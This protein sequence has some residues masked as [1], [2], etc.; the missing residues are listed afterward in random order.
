MLFSKLKDSGRPAVITLVLCLMWA[1]ACSFI[2]DYP[3]AF[4][5][6]FKGKL[7]GY[8]PPWVY[9]VPLILAALFFVIFFDEYAKGTLKKQAII[10]ARIV[11]GY[12][13][14][15]FLP[16]YIIGMNLT[17]LVLWV[18]LPIQLFGGFIII[19]LIS[20]AIRKLSESPARPETVAPIAS[21][22]AEAPR[23]ASTDKAAL[24]N[25]WNLQEN[26]SQEKL[27]ASYLRLAENSPQSIL[28]K[29]ETEYELLT[30]WR[31]GNPID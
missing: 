20:L 18:E 3:R 28:D 21:P 2:W 22:E 23:P 30:K 29:I 12:A 14:L 16:F 5:L 15:F 9:P 11:F 24:L 26:Y 13:I 25:K 8:F 19:M 17:E 10:L 31:A 6:L 27:D 4:E 7:H 1:V